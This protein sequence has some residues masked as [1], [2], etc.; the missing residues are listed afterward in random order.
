MIVTAPLGL[1]EGVWMLGL[2]GNGLDQC[3][4]VQLQLAQSGIEFDDGAVTGQ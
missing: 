4:Q 1:M 2:L 3:T